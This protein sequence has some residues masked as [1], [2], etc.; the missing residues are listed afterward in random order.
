VV[1]LADATAPP[2][3]GC[4]GTSATLAMTLADT[5]FKVSVAS[6]GVDL[7]SLLGGI[8]LLGVGVM[9]VIAWRMPRWR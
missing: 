7:Q 3:E 6:T 8:L 5:T 4:G 1:A 2:A 9:L